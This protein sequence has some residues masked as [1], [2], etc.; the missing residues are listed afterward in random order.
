MLVNRDNNGRFIVT[1]IRTL[2][3]CACGCGKQRI[4]HD[5]YGRPKKF[6][7]GH[8]INIDNPNKGGSKHPQWKGG[9]QNSGNYIYLYDLTHPRHRRKRSRIVWEEANNACLLPYPMGVV[10]HKNG[11]KKDDRPDNLEGMTESQHA[12]LERLLRLF[13][14][15]NVS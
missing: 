3:E 13:L 8:Q 4:S 6:I 14:S 10:H 15:P 9:I 2:V 5:K 1:C 11:D 7:K 12:R